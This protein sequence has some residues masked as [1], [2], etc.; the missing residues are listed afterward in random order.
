[1]FVM[2]EDGKLYVFAIE[3]KAPDQSDYFSKKK[4][5][6]SGDLALDS[7]IFVKDLPPLKM[8]ATGLDHFLG[9]DAKGQVHA[10]GDD[11]F[12]QC[13]QG[14]SGRQYIAPFFE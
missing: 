3:E 11:T 9:L 6:F 5:E 14:G 7:P 1:M 12:G 13:G 4:P 10:M 8:I 2:S